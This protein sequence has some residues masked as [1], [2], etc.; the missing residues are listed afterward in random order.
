MKGGSPADEAIALDTGVPEALDNPIRRPLLL[1]GG[2]VMP[3]DEQIGDLV[4]GDVLVVDG[5]IAAVGADLRETAP[6]GALVIDTTGAVVMP[7]FQDAHRHCWQSAF[8]RMFSD[9][10]IEGYM[11]ACHDLLAPSYTPHDIYVGCQLSA[12]AA[13]DAGITSVLDF[14]H[15][16]RTMDY[17]FE[18]ARAFHDAGLR[19]VHTFG[20]P[21]KGRWDERWPHTLPE[22][23]TAI[24]SFELTTLR[25]GTWGDP[26]LKQPTKLIQPELVE[27]ARSA[28]VGLTADAVFGAGSSEVVSRLAASGHLGPDISLI[29]CNALTDEAWAA[30]AETGTGVIM[31]PTS[32]TW[33]GIYDATPPIEAVIQR[34]IDAAL[35]ID[36]ECSLSSDMFTAMRTVLTVQR[37]AA[38]RRNWQAPQN[39]PTE[40]LTSRQVLQ[41]A[42]R[43]GAKTAG[44][45]GV[46]GSL[47]PGLRADLIVVGT[48]EVNN[49]PLNDASASVALGSDPRNVRLVVVDGVI[50]KWG[51]KL[52]G[53]DL[54][55]L[56]VAAYESRD[57]LI[58]ESGTPE[59]PPSWL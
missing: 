33:L 16:S 25:L 8:R 47:K 56:R 49:L 24:E 30:I 29:H 55:E 14:M 50:K 15:N 44:L 19:C 59:R 17:A 36:V 26:A 45:D 58:R 28:G 10:D 35:S 32:D 41:M 11:T 34:G 43:N 42:T 18:A 54:N 52:I 4:A 12:W 5:A 37:M 27:L 2:Y 39:R 22:M 7:G 21:S 6:D 9:H 1:S 51:N 3:F 53:L 40:S 13:I 20:P 57:R 23:Q 48:D 31:C 38:H 46:V